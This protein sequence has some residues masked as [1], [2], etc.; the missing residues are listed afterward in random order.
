MPFAHRPPG[1]ASKPRAFVNPFTNCDF[2]AH[3]R[4]TAPLSTAS[5]TSR[6]NQLR[7]V[8]YILLHGLYEG[9]H[10][11]Y[12]G[13]PRHR[14]EPAGRFHRG[15]LAFH[16]HREEW[17]LLAP[18]IGRKSV[19]HRS[20]GVAAYRLIQWTTRGPQ[21]PASEV[22]VSLLDMGFSSVLS[23]VPAI[24][25]VDEHLLAHR[26]SLPKSLRLILRLSP[27]I[28]D[29]PAT[30]A[31]LAA[32]RAD[33]WPVA[34]DL[35]SAPHQT[36]MLAAA[37]YA[38]FRHFDADLHLPDARAAGVKCII[39]DVPD[40]SAAEL[41]YRQSHWV[42]PAVATVPS[43]RRLTLCPQRS[44]A[45]QLIARLADLQSP[46]SEIERLLSLDPMLSFRV[47][48][49]ANSAAYGRRQPIDTLT[50]AI[51]LLGRNELAQWVGV[52]TLAHNS[53]A[54]S[55]TVVNALVRA[56]MCQLLA[57]YLGVFEPDRAFT[58]GLV[59]VFD[60]LLRISPTDV[61][62]LIE[63][64]PDVRAAVL[65]RRGQLGA[66]L[67]YAEAHEK[68]Q[69]SVIDT[70]GLEPTMVNTSWTRAL[71]WAHRAVDAASA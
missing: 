54:Q 63:A 51:T 41:Y 3:R 22:L 55:E 52:L 17:Q 46:T 66:I 36:G 21:L 50:A 31:A 37:Q 12:H 45:L 10:S 8:C 57:G 24:L 7:C 47:L 43:A 11:A 38:C 58:V 27:Q 23:G 28:A 71:E 67:S 32:V 18:Y 30:R 29:S 60:T 40:A 59:S 35:S 34:I 53:D 56:K 68:Q 44:S 9:C 15:T 25:D 48:Q 26:T 64:A 5:R 42:E 13:V 4:A 2:G 69:W 61:L 19:Y 1:R 14:T 62:N 16:L 70:G 65:H 6:S 33:G 39:T 49:I 20:G